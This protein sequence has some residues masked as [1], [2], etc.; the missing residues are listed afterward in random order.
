VHSSLLRLAAL[1]AQP[2]RCS[3][4][5]VAATRCH[6]ADWHMRPPSHGYPLEKLCT[7]ARPR[8]QL[9]GGC[10]FRMSRWAHRT[11]SVSSARWPSAT[12]RCACWIPDI[13]YFAVHRASCRRSQNSPVIMALWPAIVLWVTEG[14]L[15]SILLGKICFCC[16][17]VNQLTYTPARELQLPC[18]CKRAT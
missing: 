5:Y 4:A 9:P 10:W 2:K 6:V 1:K 15:L 8:R 16:H 17:H 13:H 11:Q 7:Q 3:P 14:C 18:Q 12:S